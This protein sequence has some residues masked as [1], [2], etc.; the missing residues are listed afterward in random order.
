MMR[1]TL[2]VLL[3]LTGCTGKETP[4]DDV[5][6]DADVDVD[7]D[8]DLDGE[9]LCSDMDADGFGVGDCCEGSDCDDSNPE[10]FRPDQCAALCKADP[11]ATGCACDTPEPEICYFGPDGTIGIGSCR[12]GLHLCVD[13][14]W[15]FC[16]GQVL[17]Q[18]EVCD[19]EDNNC[20]GTIDE[21]VQSACGDCN[22]EC[23][24]GC[25]GIDCK[26]PFE[27]DAD[28]GLAVDADGALVLEPGSTSGAL[29]YLL[30]DPCR[31]LCT[32]WADLW[33]NVETPAGTSFVVEAR[34]ADAPGALDA[35]PWIPMAVVPDDES[36]APLPFEANGPNYLEIRIEL[37]SDDDALT[38]RVLSVGATFACAAKIC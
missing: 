18:G 16:E 17:P 27:P 12:G 21:G 38:P 15:G 30:A 24:D 23:N 28:S 19:E 37:R 25:V 33:W 32:L 8:A 5:L 11:S 10:V 4:G 31:G 29:R 3:P 6:A 26:D 14:R 35:E 7:A 1:I 2:A 22:P 20:D 34:A 13:G 9:C 36:P